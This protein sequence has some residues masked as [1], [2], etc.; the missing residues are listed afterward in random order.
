[1]NGITRR[2]VLFS[3]A[4]LVAGVSAGTAEAATGSIALKIL[5]GGFI[6]G[7]GGGSG[8]LTF[9]G[10]RYPLS[11]SGV[12]LGAT[13]GVSEAELVGTAFYVHDVHDIEGAYSAASAGVAVAG[14]GGVVQLSNAR[15]VLLR[16]QGRQVGFKLSL[17]VS[18]LTISLA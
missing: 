3:G 11:L 1:M 7:V 16:L 10:V 13:I 8:V 9:Q 14:G 12:S 18:G 17:A 15:G 5:S 4:V 2:G 6:L